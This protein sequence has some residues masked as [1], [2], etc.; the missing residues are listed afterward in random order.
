[1]HVCACLRVTFK[2][3]GG[4]LDAA[5]PAVRL[6]HLGPV[7]IVCICVH[8]HVCAC[9]RVTFKARGGGLDTAQHAVRQAQLGPVCMHACVYVCV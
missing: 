6:A 5:E 3:R 8:V 2:A 7:C 4:G 1:V 9:L